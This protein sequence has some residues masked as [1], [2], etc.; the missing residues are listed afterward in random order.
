MFYWWL[1][2]T[3]NH[4]DHQNACGMVAFRAV[5]CLRVTVSA[6]GIDLT[7]LYPSRASVSYEN[8]RIYRR[9]T[10]SIHPGIFALRRGKYTTARRQYIRQRSWPIAPSDMFLPSP[11]GSRGRGR[12]LEVNDFAV[13]PAGMLDGL[14][15]L[16]SL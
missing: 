6:V 7:V 14:A 2:N 15:S 8:K 16:T 9:L 1:L 10:G 13:F 5:S 11:L 3:I 4:R 12:N